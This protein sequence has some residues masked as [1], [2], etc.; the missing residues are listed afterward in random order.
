MPLDTD[1]DI[2]L[3]NPNTGGSY[4]NAGMQNEY[5]GLGYLSSSLRAV[6]YPP[7]LVDS[8]LL[9]LSVDSTIG[10]VTRELR[11]IVGI[12]MFTETAVPWVRQLTQ[13]IKEESPKTH[14]VLGGYY[15][16][17]QTERALKLVPDA[18][19]IVRGE[20]EQT[21]VE[22]AQRI[23]AGEQWRETPGLAYRHDDTETTI[24][25]PN[26]NLVKDLDTLPFPD[27]YAQANQIDELLIEGSRGCFNRC[28]FCALHP[29]ISPPDGSTAWRG[30]SPE[31]IVEEM[32][33]LRKSH[34]SVKRFRFIDPCFF[35]SNKMME[36]N[37]RLAKMIEENVP[38]VELVVEGRVVDIQERARTLLQSLKRAGLKEI[39]V[40]LEAGSEKILRIMRKGFREEQA[41]NGL[42]ILEE[43]RL[44]YEF[45]FMMF[46]PWTEEA[47]VDENIA[48]LK[49][50]GFLDLHLLFRQMDV[51][52]A[53]PAME[54]SGEL[55]PKGNSGY[56]TYE[57]AHGI[58]DLKQFAKV[59]ESTQKGFFEDMFEIYNKIRM[60]YEG[61]NREIIE[62]SK[63]LNN[64]I[65]DVFE[66]CRARVKLGED[67]AE[68]ATNCVGKFGPQ[69]RIIYDKLNI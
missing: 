47:N 39:Y 35:G 48:F 57:N 36:R 37:M 66:Y 19:S 43:E 56:Y 3:V 30:R 51:I 22:L 2:V 16:T 15:P 61:G 46:T 44:F 40:G 20:G 45:G 41:L 17:L 49:Q 4:R 68:V 10:E 8:R 12:A 50:I 69:V 24:F 54:N 59:L 65:T 60:A 63:E 64:I 7:Q 1:K 25:T 53:T 33:Q 11:K 52:P 34:P 32:K 27:R 6:G 23:Q 9:N 21:L 28:V 42:R 5:P 31:H 55:T 67:F 13:A 62:I 58:E 38:D 29:F 26:R 14:V 18:D